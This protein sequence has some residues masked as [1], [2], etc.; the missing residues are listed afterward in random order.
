MPIDLMRF[1]LLQDHRRIRGTLPLIAL[2][3]PLMPAAL[4]SLPYCDAGGPL[5]DDEAIEKAL[6]LKALEFSALARSLKTSGTV[7]IRSPHPFAGVDP[8]MSVNREKARMTLQLPGS[9]DALLSSLKAKVRSQVKKPIRDGLTAEIGRKNLLPEFYPLFAENM[10]DL[11]SP[12]HSRKWIESILKAYCNRAQ[13]VVVR[14][15]DGT[16]AAGGVLR[17]CCVKF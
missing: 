16:P 12:V 1:T 11:G 9:S 17:S 3:I 10:R 8:E 5:A 2:K 7:T 15:P 4:I 6:V 14:M 13:L